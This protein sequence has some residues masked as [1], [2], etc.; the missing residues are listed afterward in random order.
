MFHFINLKYAFKWF[1]TFSNYAVLIKSNYIHKQYW[2]WICHHLFSEIAHHWH[3]YRST[4]TFSY[5][6]T[7]IEDSEMFN[8]ILW[9]SELWGKRKIKKLVLF[10]M[11]SQ[12]DLA[13]RFPSCRDV[14]SNIFSCLNHDDSS[15]LWEVILY[16]CNLFYSYIETKIDKIERQMTVLLK[17]L[18]LVENFSTFSCR[19]LYL[20]I[21]AQLVLY[22]LDMDIHI[23]I[24]TQT[25]SAG[26]R[27]IKD[28][29]IFWTK[30]FFKDV[31]LQC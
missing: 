26:T 31:L 18:V 1:S 11:H 28:N 29:K 25:W 2:Q 16:K 24:G 15:N 14:I 3:E 23:C 10:S 4:L 22:I 20:W 9:K 27:C 21:N 17:L 13:H 6:Y 5:M 7:L 19:S 8:S 30:S 12:A